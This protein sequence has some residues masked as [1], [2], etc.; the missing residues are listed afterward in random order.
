M[1]VSGQPMSPR[2]HLPLLLG[3]LRRW[4]VAPRIARLL[5]PPPAPGL[6]CGRGGEALGLAL[7]AGHQALS[8]GGSGRA[9]RGRVALVQPGVT[10]AALQDDRLGHILE[11]LLAAHRNAVLRAVA[12][13]ALEV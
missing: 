5:P 9:A 3:V 11:A 10:R 6:A 7:L 2:A 4:E 12:L 13:H 8:T 1:A